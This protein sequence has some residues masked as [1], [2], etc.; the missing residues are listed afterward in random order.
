MK[1]LVLGGYGF[2]GSHIV[3][4]LKKQNHTVAVVDC[5]HQYYTL[6]DMQR[7]HYQARIAFVQLDQEEVLLL[8]LI[9]NI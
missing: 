9:P 2:I 1:I 5:Y 8:F 4:K 6:Q 7:Q 3:N